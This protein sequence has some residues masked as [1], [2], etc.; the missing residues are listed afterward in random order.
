MAASAAAAAA[1]ML[2]HGDATHDT[3]NGSQIH[4]GESPCTQC[5]QSAVAAAARSVH[6]LIISKVTLIRFDDKMVSSKIMCCD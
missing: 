6:S 2:V 5:I 4:F 1:P 3:W